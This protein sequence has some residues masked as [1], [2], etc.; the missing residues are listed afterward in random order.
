MSYDFIFQT[1]LTKKEEKKAVLPPIEKQTP[2]FESL[3]DLE[4]T[5][6]VLKE[7]RQEMKK[8]MTVRAEKMLRS[9]LKDMEIRFGTKETKKR[10]EDSIVS[11]WSDVYEPKLTQEQRRAQA[12]E[13][14]V[15][16][17]KEKSDRL[18]EKNRKLLF[19]NGIPA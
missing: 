6:M 5:F 10:I 13:E 2:S 1:L 18:I 7:Q 15:R 3:G 11:G 16:I 4:P 17:E 12:E 14:R 9:K 19:P 8:P